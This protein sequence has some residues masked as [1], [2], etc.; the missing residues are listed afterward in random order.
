[1]ETSDASSQLG[2]RLLRR[3][4]DQRP[5][6][7]WLLAVH[8]QPASGSPPFEVGLHVPRLTL[9]LAEA[10]ALQ[11]LGPLPPAPAARPADTRALMRWLVEMTRS[12]CTSPE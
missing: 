10:A 6:L 2:A 11:R 9:Q 7:S 8:R 12:D 5:L 1:M 3:S 4:G